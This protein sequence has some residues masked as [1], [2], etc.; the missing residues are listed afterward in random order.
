MADELQV[1]RTILKWA[2]IPVIYWGT[3]LGYWFTCDEE[4][5]FTITL[6]VGTW[7]FCVGLVG[8]LLGGLLSGVLL[9]LMEATRDQL[10]EI[11]LVSV[12]GVVI[13][14]Y[15]GYRLHRKYGYIGPQ[16]NVHID[17]LSD[18]DENN[19]LRETIILEDETVV[20]GRDA[21]YLCQNDDCGYE[22]F[23]DEEFC[24]HCGTPKSRPIVPDQ[25]LICG[26]CNR[27][28]H[29]EAKFCPGCGSQ[30]FQR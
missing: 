18:D 24:S 29:D 5:S 10:P 11:W 25:V 26:Q 12:L 8:F 19:S 3:M 27:Q 17:Q 16:R 23:E 15:Y 1:Y 28:L 21:P 4:N 13:G 2:S 6:S 30:V 22:L 7:V 14:V 9:A 20:K